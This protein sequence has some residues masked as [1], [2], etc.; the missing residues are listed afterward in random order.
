MEDDLSSSVKQ[1]TFEPNSLKKSE[2]IREFQ[3]DTGEVQII[4][5]KKTHKSSTKKQS[6][7][8]K[9]WVCETP[10]NKQ[11]GKVNMWDWKE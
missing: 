10:K 2:S 6:Q 11:G 1:V 8:I 4:K 3:T 5:K 9:K 7:P